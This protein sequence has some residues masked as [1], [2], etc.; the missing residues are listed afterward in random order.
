MT[1]KDR[2]ELAYWLR[3][4]PEIHLAKSRMYLDRWGYEDVDSVLEIGTGPFSGFGPFIK[5]N[6]KLGLDPLLNAY[7]T[8][9]V[10]RMCEDMQYS[11]AYFE[12]F[13]TDERFDAVLTSDC[14][15]HGDMDFRVVPKLASFLK[16][17]GKLYIHVHLRPP[18]KLNRIHDHS[19]K[20]E[21]LD[22]EL[23]KTALIE[24]KREILPKD[25]DGKFCPALMGVWRN[26]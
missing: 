10:F 20:V 22:E 4:D 23:K 13:E 3:T 9:G 19:L 21:Q 17:G 7:R 26:G 12:D 25:I 16:P 11:D 5:A 6:R 24:E 18:G 15:D 2:R 1:E 8:G 14:I